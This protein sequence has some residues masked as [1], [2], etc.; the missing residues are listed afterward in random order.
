MLWSTRPDSCYICCGT[1][2]SA[3]SAAT[4]TFCACSHR[5]YNLLSWC[6]REQLKPCS[7]FFCVVWHLFYSDRALPWQISVYKQH[8]TPLWEWR[9]TVHLAG[10]RSNNSCLTWPERPWLK[11]SLLL[12]GG[13][14]H[15]SLWT[16]IAETHGHIMIMIGGVG[17][18]LS[19]HSKLRNGCYTLTWMD[20]DAS[21]SIHLTS[22]PVYE[23]TNGNRTLDCPQ[24]ITLA[25]SLLLMQTTANF[26][27]LISL[28]LVW[29]YSYLLL[30]RLC[31]LGPMSHLW[32]STPTL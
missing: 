3:S 23:E 14:A 13:K 20:G 16:G 5:Y 19:R 18:G 29:A 7:K 22:C 30:S 10:H 4:S 12:K 11:S 32:I 24:D 17:W 31:G 21:K 8:L 26:Y 2:D 25:H 27:P 28:S 15:W 9:M 6:C 1:C